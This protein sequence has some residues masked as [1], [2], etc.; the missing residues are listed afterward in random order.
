MADADWLL[1]KPAARRL[2]ED[3]DLRAAQE[4][5]GGEDIDLESFAPKSAKDFE[6]LGRFVSIKFFNPHAKSAH[7][8]LLLKALLKE[9]LQSL[10]VQQVKDVETS[11]AGIRSDKL[12]EEK[13]RAASSKGVPCSRTEPK[14]C[15]SHAL[16]MSVCCLLSMPI[17][18]GR[19]HCAAYAICRLAFVVNRGGMCSYWEEEEFECW[20]WRRYSRVG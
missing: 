14:L 1:L 10:E 11:I 6:Q 15:L 5:F 8:K 7:Y 2:V 4:L 13:A 12:K 9:A 17:M 18:L 20:T 16:W 19:E 3:A